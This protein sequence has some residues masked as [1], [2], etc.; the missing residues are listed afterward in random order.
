MT[1]C[2]VRMD[3]EGGRHGKRRSIWRQAVFWVV[4]IERERGRQSLGWMTKKFR[5]L[6]VPR[7]DSLGSKTSRAESLNDGGPRV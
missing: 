4:G 3:F 6:G 1:V 7:E 5:S 2:A